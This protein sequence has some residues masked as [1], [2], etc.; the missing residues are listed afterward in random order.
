MNHALPN[1]FKNFAWQAGYGVFSL[2]SK[3]LD[4]AVA[5]VQNQKTHHAKGSIITSLE[6]ETNDDDM[7]KRWH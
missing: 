5:Y 2:G 6:Q 1:S 7:P 4:Q 3:Q